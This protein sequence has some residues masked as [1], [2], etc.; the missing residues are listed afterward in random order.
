MTKKSTMIDINQIL[1]AE[2]AKRD[3]NLIDSKRR[4]EDGIR[5]ILIPEFNQV[6]GFST[7]TEINT[8]DNRQD[9]KLKIFT[10]DG[11]VITCSGKNVQFQIEVAHIIPF[12]TAS[13]SVDGHLHVKSAPPENNL[14]KH[15]GIL[16][17][18]TADPFELDRLQKHN[19]DIAVRLLEMI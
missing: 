13:I 16:I 15:E 12:N 17:P 11:Q 9:Q 10:L 14:W 4:I 3:L 8:K 2:Q 19:R 6:L 7:E 5:N 1:G 18:L